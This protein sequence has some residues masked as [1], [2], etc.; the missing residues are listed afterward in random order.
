[1]NECTMTAVE[2]FENPRNRGRMPNPDGIGGIGDL[3]QG[4]FLRVFI[5]VENNIITDVKYEIRDC[6]TSIA[7]ASIMTELVVGKDL[8]EAMMIE[9]EDIVDALGGLPEEMLY[10]SNR[11]ATG[12]HEAIINHVYGRVK[13]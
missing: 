3:S 13:R 11:A 5:R 10:C 4:D 1:M 9:N 2:H 12:L 7:C 8:D 6:P